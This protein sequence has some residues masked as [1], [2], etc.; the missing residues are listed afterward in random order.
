MVAVPAPGKEVSGTRN[1]PGGG[2]AAA[3]AEGRGRFLGEAQGVPHCFTRPS[4]FLT[5]GE[6]DCVWKGLQEVP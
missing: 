3:V 5:I 6:G 1:H 2:R 4:R